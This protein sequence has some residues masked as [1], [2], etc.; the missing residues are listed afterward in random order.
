LR[1]TFVFPFINLTGGI[2]VHIDYANE[3]SAAGHEVTVVYPSWPYRFQYNWLVQLREFRRNLQNEVAI[4]WYALKANLLRVPFIRTPFLPEADVVIAVGWPTVHDVFRL[5]R[6]RGRKVHIVMH[7]ESGTGPEEEIRK[8][9][10]FP[11]YRIAYSSIVAAQIQTEFNCK[12]NEVVPNGVNRNVFYPETKYRADRKV[13]MLYHPDPRKGAR[14]GLEALAELR[15]SMPDLNIHLVGPVMP[16]V[17]LPKGMNFTFYPSD[18]ELRHLYNTSTVLLYP[19]RV[20][21]FGLPP[22]EAMAC[23][24]PVVTTSVGAIPEFAINNHNAFVVKP[25]DS[26]SMA[27][28]LSLLLHNSELRSQFTT[29]GLHTAKKYSLSEVAPL[30]EFALQKALSID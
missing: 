16:S 9:Y 29:E 14:D 17:L 18:A 5:H 15:F 24:C 19:S 20:E 23:G 27:D 4:Q 6:S 26:R 28:K 12:V 10:L 1:I 30:F 21:G 7:H 2:R 8:I 13:L 11:F 25:G 22:L 3:L